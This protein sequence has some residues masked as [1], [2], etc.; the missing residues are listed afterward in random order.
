MDFRDYVIIS[1][2]TCGTCKWGLL[3]I[4]QFDETQFVL[5]PLGGICSLVFLV[6][7]LNAVHDFVGGLVP[8]GMAVSRL[9]SPPKRSW[10]HETPVSSINL[11]DCFAI[12]RRS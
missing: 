8:M 11:R 10:D 7:E 4:R 12:G 1:L 9:A 3:G 6:E 5:S 2:V